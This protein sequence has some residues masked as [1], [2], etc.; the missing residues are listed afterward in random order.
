[1]S[2]HSHW[3]GIKHKKGLADAKRSQ[4]FSK[5]ARELTIAA[6]EG[7]SDPMTNP[8]LRTVIEKARVANM[9]TENVER[10]LKRAAGE[11]VGQLDRK[12]T[13]LNSSHTSI[14]YSVFFLR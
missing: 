1:M 10:A 3:A 14:S 7:G 9:P 12:S 13:R 11:G 8:R 5:L 2:G 6:K 4:L